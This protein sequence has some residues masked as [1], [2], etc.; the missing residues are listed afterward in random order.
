MIMMIE[1]YICQCQNEMHLWRMLLFNWP[2][3]KVITLQHIIN[4]HILWLF[5][6]ERIT[7]KH[8]QPKVK[9]GFVFLL[10]LFP[11]IWPPK[12]DFYK[13]ITLTSSMVKV[14]GW[15]LTGKKFQKYLKPVTKWYFPKLI[16][17]MTKYTLKEF[18]PKMSPP[19]L[20]FFH[21]PPPLAIKYECTLNII[22]TI[23]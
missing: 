15:I 17:Y 7:G 16:Y 11:S 5:F 21:P 1:K 4:D 18:C 19:L 23:L 13:P 9:Y 10:L 6:M 20:P 12:A 3:V 14:L 22:V 8:R 2:K